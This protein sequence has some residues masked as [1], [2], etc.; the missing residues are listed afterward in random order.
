MFGIESGDAAY[1]PRL[2]RG[3]T[4]IHDHLEKVEAV[5]RF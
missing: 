1:P 2:A 5:P 4:S 3:Q